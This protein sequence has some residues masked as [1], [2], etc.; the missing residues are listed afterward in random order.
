MAT[1]NQLIADHKTI[2]HLKRQRAARLARIIG[3]AYYRWRGK[4]MDDMYRFICEEFMAMGG[5]YVKF[6]QGVLLRSDM[7]RAWQSPE[8]LRV[9][10]NLDTEPIEVTS[11]LQK[12]LPKEKLAHITN[13]NP[14]P[15]AAGSFGQVYFGQHIG[16][17]PIIIKIL[18]PMIRETLKF[19]LKLLS[20]FMRRFSKR[21]YPNTDMDLRKPIEDFKNATMR[22]T[23]YP[24]EAAFAAEMHRIYKDHPKFIIPETFTELCTENI[25]VQEYIDGISAAHLVKIKEQGFDPH[26]YVTQYLGSDLDEQLETIGFEYIVGIFALERVQG[27]PHPGNIRLMKDNKVGLIDFGIYARTPREKPALF[28]LLKEYQHMYQGKLD[29]ADLFGQFMRFFSP[30]LYLALDRINM[31]LP[32][33]QQSDNLARDIGTVAAEGFDK[34]TNNSSVQQ[35]I[36]DGSILKSINQLTNKDN[37][38]GIIM[39]VESADML[40]AA[41]TYITLVESLGSDKVLPHVFEK[42]LNKIETAYG[43]FT[44]DDGNPLSVNRAVEVIAAW[45]ERVAERDPVLFNVLS[46]KMRSGEK[47]AREL[48]K[49]IQQELNKK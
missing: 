36:K 18:R 48:E 49:T 10:E 26:D 37:R 43:H 2:Q 45:L 40:R 25:I 29:V 16:G 41:Q 19:D 9:F 27:D 1:Q 28:G 42:S 4:Q 22:E 5:V 8:R 21:L 33:E 14:E 6:L 23:D 44:H 34:K 12:E 31:L 24:G 11:F 20:I 7:M 30:E 15:F 47:E 38:F 3:G 39:R 17:K 13:I 46:A 35:M 32:S